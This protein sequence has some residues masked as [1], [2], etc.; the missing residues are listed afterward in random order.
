MPVALDRDGMT[1]IGDDFVA[2]AKLAHEA[3]FDVLEL[4]MA[5]GQLLASF[6]SPLSNLR[7]DNY[8]GSVAARARC[9]LE[10]LDA[11]RVAWLST[12]LV[13]PFAPSDDE[14]GGIEPADAIAIARML[15]EHGCDAVHVMSGQTTSAAI[16]PYR[17]GFLTAWSE[18]LRHEAGIA[19]IVGGYITTADEVN[20]ALAA[21]RADVCVVEASRV[22]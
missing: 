13:V 16:P 14:R 4:D 19:T 9:P 2:A 8:G 20:T 10:V 11:V 22:R 17:R 3:G 1:R 18:R 5:H 7:T 21:G 12:P 6:L 15:R